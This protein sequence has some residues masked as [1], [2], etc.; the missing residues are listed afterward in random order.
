MICMR[1]GNLTI[2]REPS[3]VQE[4]TTIYQLTDSHLIINAIYFSVCA[5]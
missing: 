1:C 2:F 5:V 3:A 4:T